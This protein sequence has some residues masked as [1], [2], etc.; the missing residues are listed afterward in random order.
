MVSPAQLRANKKYQDV[1]YEQIQFR[2]PKGEKA[3][4]QEFAKA[5]GMSLREYIRR[6]CYEKHERK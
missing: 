6:A 4:L 5:A 3:L 2:V 1:N